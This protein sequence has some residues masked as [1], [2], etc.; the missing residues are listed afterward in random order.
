MKDEDRQDD[1]PNKGII[2]DSENDEEDD[3]EGAYDMEPEDDDDEGFENEDGK[4]NA[5]ANPEKETSDPAL[6]IVP[7]VLRRLIRPRRVIRVGR[8]VIRR[9]RRRRSRR[10][11]SRRRRRRSRG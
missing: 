4:E 6:P 10:G 8:R 3:E 1:N 5:L 9:F 2:N 11:S 7:I